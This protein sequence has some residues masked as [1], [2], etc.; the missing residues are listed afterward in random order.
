[1][2]EA[3]CR[4]REV[5][6]RQLDTEAGSLGSQKTGGRSEAHEEKQFWENA[7]H[8]P[9]VQVMGSDAFCQEGSGHG[10][11]DIFLL[12]TGFESGSLFLLRP[13]PHTSRPREQLEY[14]MG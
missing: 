2:R 10:W 13:C 5:P 4:P 8:Q 6:T 3:A 7:G 9:H 12:G 11:A 14:V 1:M